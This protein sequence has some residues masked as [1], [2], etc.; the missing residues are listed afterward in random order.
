M[1]ETRISSHWKAIWRLSI[2][3]CKWYIET[4]A[5]NSGDSLSRDAIV[6]RKTWSRVQISFVSYPSSSSARM[7]SKTWQI[8]A[9]LALT[10][11]GRNGGYS[12]WKHSARKL[13]WGDVFCP[14]MNRIYL[15]WRSMSS[16]VTVCSPSD[17]VKTLRTLMSHC[18]SCS[19]CKTKLSSQSQSRRSMTFHRAPTFAGSI[20]EMNR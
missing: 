20:E 1:L 8:N 18:W 17:S 7:P 12:L 3:D 2:I 15:V 4:S 14:R 5:P 10:P 11:N 16:N 19:C 6:D 9:M 13:E